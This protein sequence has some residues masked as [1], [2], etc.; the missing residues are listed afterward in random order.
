[1]DYYYKIASFNLYGTEGKLSG[2]VMA[3]TK[4]TPSAVKGLNVKTGLNFIDLKWN[5]SPETDITAYILYRSKNNGY[6]S[7]IKEIETTETIYRDIDLVP[8]AKY[9]YKIIVRDDDGL[10]SNP[11]QSNIIQSPI[12]KPGK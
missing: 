4:P 1:M 2:T 12:T 5:K 10:E 6:W 3:R 7:K 9:K 8:D 11:V